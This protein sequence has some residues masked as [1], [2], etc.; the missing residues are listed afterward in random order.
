METTGRDTVE[1]FLERIRQA[2]DVGDADAYAR[3]FAEDA[4]YVIFLGDAMFGRAA[5]GQTH[6]EVFTKWQKGTRMIISPI[7]V[8]TVDTDTAVVTT[9]GGIGK[10]NNIDYDKF[11]TYTL[12]RRD[13][14]WECVAFQ[15]TEMSRRAKRTYRA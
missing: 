14:R 13:G 12:R 8:R 1:A 10:G 11:Q 5:I 3:Q 9:V 7:D 6:H 4:S 2:W 15:N